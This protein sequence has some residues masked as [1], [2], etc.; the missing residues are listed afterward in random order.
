MKNAR[1][2]VIAACLP[3]AQRPQPGQPAVR[4]ADDQHVRRA[5]VLLPAG[6][7][8]GSSQVDRGLVGGQHRLGRQGGLH[9][10]IEPGVFQPGG[11]PLAG[12]IHEPGRDRHAQQHA[13]QVRGPLRGHVPVGGQQHRRGVDP[14]PVGD[15]ARVRP[16]RRL[17][18]VHLPAARAGQQRQQVLGHERR[19][20]HVP[21]LRPPGTRPV[22]AVQAGPAPRALR[23]RR[24][25]LP[26]R[27]GPGPATAPRRDARAARR[28]CG[29]CAVPVPRTAAAFRSA[30]RRSR[31]PI[32]SFDGGVPE[33]VLSDP[34]R[35]SSSA[36]LSSSRRYRSR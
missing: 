3:G 29:P 14:R 22:R 19:D 6:P 17:R 10:L 25:L 2:A 16:R 32:G 20:L 15:A 4:G 24:H 11:Q 26:A 23:R 33:V 31:A 35:R 36:T 28:A 9:R 7:A 34:S 30:L 18:G 5:R 27:P 12:Q 21:D 8:C 1:T 13:D